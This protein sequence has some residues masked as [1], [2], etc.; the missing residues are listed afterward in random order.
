MSTSATV[1]II[2]PTGTVRD[3]PY[4]SIHDAIS[5]GGKMGVYMLDPQGA[6]RV[7]PADQ[8]QDASAH[9]G[10]VVPYNLDQIPSEARLLVGTWR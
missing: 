2:D 10:K 9:G 3:V 4:E 5:H 8:V 6:Q 1:P 7:V